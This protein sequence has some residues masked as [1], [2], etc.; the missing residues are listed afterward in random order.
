MRTRKQSAKRRKASEEVAPPVPAPQP[1]DPKKKAKTNDNFYALAKRAQ[2]EVLPTD[3]ERHVRLAIE[4]TRQKASRGE[5]LTLYD[6]ENPVIRKR[7]AEVLMKDHGFHTTISGLA[8][9]IRLLEPNGPQ[10]EGGS[11]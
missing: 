1:A 6:V 4:K 2:T 3:V 10:D 5:M 7:V 11:E 9:F 8:I